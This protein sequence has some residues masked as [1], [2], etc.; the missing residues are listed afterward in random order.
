LQQADFETVVAFPRPDPLEVPGSREVSTVLRDPNGIA[1]KIDQ[2]ATLI[3]TAPSRLVS[4]TRCKTITSRIPMLPPRV[5]SAGMPH[6][7]RQ[8]IAV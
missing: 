2:A 6:A 8:V 5:G 7:Q 4:S 3:S 1:S